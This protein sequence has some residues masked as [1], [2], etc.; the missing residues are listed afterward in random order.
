[1]RGWRTALLLVTATGLGLAAGVSGAD[2][3]VGAASAATAVGRDGLPEGFPTDLALPVG[4][5][6]DAYRIELDRRTLYRVTYRVAD[7][8]A[9]LSAMADSL[10]KNGWDAKHSGPFANGGRAV[11]AHRSGRELT[12]TVAPIPGSTASTYTMVDIEP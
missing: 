7:G 2:R 3:R 4:T 11:L 1:M 5:K 8:E 12:V 10:T 9:N 6:Q